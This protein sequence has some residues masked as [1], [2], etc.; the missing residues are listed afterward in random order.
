M[1]NTQTSKHVD[2]F[3]S[4][5]D[6]LA[7]KNP[8]EYKEFV[9]HQ[10]KN[11]LDSI[12]PSSDTPEQQIL[13][14]TKFLSLRFKILKILKTTDI[15]D[16][17]LD[18]EIPKIAF[19]LNFL[20]EA[21]NKHIIQEPKI[22]LNIIHSNLFSP[23]INKDNKIETDSNKWNYIPTQFRYNGKKASLRGIKCVFYDVILHSSIIDHLKANE[24]LKKHILAY[25]CRKFSIFLNDKYVLF[26][27]NVKIL[28]NHT[29]KSVKN[30]VDDFCIEKQTKLPKSTDFLKTNKIQVPAQSENMPNTSS[31]YNPPKSKPKKKI[32][33][34]EIIPKINISFRKKVLD[35]TRMEIIFDLDSFSN[36]HKDKINLQIS[37]TEFVLTFTDVNEQYDPVYF[38]FDNFNLLPDFC[39]G[40]Y[41]STVNKLKVII[42]KE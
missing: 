31:F 11:G 30:T 21:F 3:W 22:Y 28:S 17:T 20:Q 33:I 14:C 1:F 37:S 29:Y 9:K 19:S 27:D 18:K 15:P 16:T 13:Q 23:P 41:D 34:E 7:E 25:L 38:A 6:E 10:L 39:L 26:L 36:M 32:L 35:N 4:Y 42:Q 40:I 8:T 2:Q 24:D 5:L 12:K